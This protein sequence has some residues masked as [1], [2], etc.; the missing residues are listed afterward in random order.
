MS[1]MMKNTSKK[2]YKNWLVSAALCVPLLAMQAVVPTLLG[3]D[4][5]T[6]GVANAQ[7]SGAKGKDGQGKPQRKTKR[8]RALNPKLSEKLLLAQEEIE[9]KNLKAADKILSDLLNGSKELDSFE[10]ANVYIIYG[11][12]YYSQENYPKALESYKFVVSAEEVP[13]GMVLNTKKTIAQLYFAMERWGEGVEAIRD[14]F[15]EKRKMGQEPGAGDYV[16]LGQGCYQLKD[17]KCSL[18]NVEKAIGIYKAK[19]KVPKE[20]WYGL[21]RFLY[22]DQENYQKVAEILEEMLVHYPKATYWSQLSGMYG[23]LKKEKKQLY[24]MDTAYVQDMLTKEGELR[25]M[26]YLFLGNEVPYKAAKV[27]DKAL[28]KEQMKDDAKN[29]ELLATSW[30]Q[31]QELD[32]SIPVMVKAAKKSDKGEL[33]A[34][35]GNIYLNNDDFQKSIDAINSALKKGGVKRP[36]SSRLVLGMAYFNLQKFDSAKKAFKKAREDKRSKEYA[37]QWLAYL[38]REVQRLEGLK[39]I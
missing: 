13:D 34:R 35:L 36:D 23:E 30:S 3:G 32:K 25:N 7:P 17:Y 38:E 27:L 5:L 22:Y 2:G 8:T 1:Y 37:D 20:N 24:A 14:W 11:F 6:A 10:K 26:A 4:D 29:L 9:N 18:T 28:K 16:L 21:Q 39:T 33:W 19:G 12:L 15:A 31:A